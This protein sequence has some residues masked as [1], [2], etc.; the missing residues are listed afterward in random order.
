MAA[1]MAA[2]EADAAERAQRRA[3]QRARATKL[4]DR[5]NTFFKAGDCRRAVELYTQ[6]IELAKD[7]DILYTNRALVCDPCVMIKM[8]WHG[9]V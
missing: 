3:A 1:F 9:F 8:C 2:V 7:W 5:A 6:A 4:K